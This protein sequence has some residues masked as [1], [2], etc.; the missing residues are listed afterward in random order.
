MNKSQLFVLW[1]IGIVISSIFYTTGQKLLVHAAAYK[2][3]WDTGYPL[4]LLGGTAWSYILPIVII[5]AILI[6]TVKGLG[7][8]RRR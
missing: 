1:V 6:Y 2:E 3:T 8:R 7:D 5:G 4:T